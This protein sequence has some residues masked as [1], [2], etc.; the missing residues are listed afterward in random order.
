M[1]LARAALPFLVVAAGVRCGGRDGSP[2]NEATPGAVTPQPP[3]FQSRYVRPPTRKRVIIFVNGVFGDATST[4]KNAA[5]GAYW[6]DLLASDHE[7]DGADLYVHSFESP[8]LSRA[9]EVLELA[10]RMKNYLDASDVVKD[11]DEIV[12]VCHSMGGLVTRAY[13]LDARLPPAKVPFIFFFGTPSAGANVAEIARHLSANPQ[14]GSMLPLDDNTYV[15]TLR[16]QWL[17]TTDDPSLDYPRKISSYCAYELKDTWGVRVVP[18]LSATYLCNRATTAI[19]A[20]HLDIVK[21]ANPDSETYV[22]FLA[23][24]KNQFGAAAQPIRMALAEQRSPI[25]RTAK[26]ELRVAS[27]A[28]ETIVLKQVRATPA[29]IEV[30]CGEEKTGQIEVPVDLASRELAVEV[31][32]EVARGGNLASSSAFLIRFDGKTAVVG[33]K[34]RGPDRSAP[35]CTAGGRGDVVVNFVVSRRRAIPDRLP[36]RTDRLRQPIHP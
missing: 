6:P 28:S 25:L 17:S 5:T 26:R 27:L 24:Y 33:Y 12:F 18:E 2:A 1:R 7:F 10:R 13:L 20:D 9:Q 34:I 14:L 32:P 30:G 4:W 8:K 3:A 22:A 31:H 35:D 29:S 11:H 16:E 19:L 23:A 21:P 15:K 36:G